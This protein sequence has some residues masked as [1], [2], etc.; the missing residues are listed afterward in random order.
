[1]STPDI[2]ADKVAEIAKQFAYRRRNQIPH[3]GHTVHRLFDALSDLLGKPVGF[4][5]PTKAM[6][7]V[8]P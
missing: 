7:Q 3:T 1:M 4:I 2:K 8:D 5:D 6:P